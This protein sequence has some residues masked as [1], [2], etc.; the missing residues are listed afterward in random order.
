MASD[1]TASSRAARASAAS[2][3]QKKNSSESMT[4]DFATSAQPHAHS[5]S[6]SVE[7]VPVSAHT[8]AGCLNVPTRF[9]PAVRFTPVLP[10]TDESTIES[11][12]V[13]ACT[14]VTPR[15][16][17][18]A[19]NPA[20]SPTTPPPSATTAQSRPSESCAMAS[21]ISL[22]TSTDFVSSPAGTTMSDTRKPAAASDSLARS[23]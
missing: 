23:R 15:M 12:V 10:P 17:V 3:S 21:H 5:R 8:Y 6:G 1:T 4:A 2:A 7:S 9:L 13:G 20:R 18:E 19:A 22:A 16:Y 14:S 11:S